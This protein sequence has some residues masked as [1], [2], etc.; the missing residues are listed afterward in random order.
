M[1]NFHL[2]RNRHLLSGC[3]AL[4]ANASRSVY[5]LRGV[6]SGR[7]T[8]YPSTV[9]TGAEQWPMAIWLSHF[10]RARKLCHAR[11]LV[12]SGNQLATDFDP[13]NLAD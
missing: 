3:A 5:N 9:A 6:P 7:V 4:I 8:A 1:T 12:S 2:C 11:A 13:E 10:P